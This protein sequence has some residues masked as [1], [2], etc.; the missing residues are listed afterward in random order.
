[1]GEFLLGLFVILILVGIIYEQDELVAKNKRLEQEAEQ[2][3]E[4]IKLER[5]ALDLERKRIRQLDAKLKLDKEKLKQKA[6]EKMSNEY[7]TSKQIVK[8][9]TLI[10]ALAI[11]IVLFFRMIYSS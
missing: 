5:M 10:V 1:M 3:R 6:V 8:S 4:A 11:C 9:L 7:L 2:Q